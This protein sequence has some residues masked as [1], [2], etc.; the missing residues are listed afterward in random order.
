MV[1][2]D[3]VTQRNAS[4]AEQ[5][6]ATTEEMSAQAETLRRLLGFFRLQLQR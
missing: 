1:Q 2:V 5:L 4:A 3:Q 6:A